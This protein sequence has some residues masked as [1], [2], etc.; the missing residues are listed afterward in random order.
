MIRRPPRSTLSSSSAASD[1]YKRQIQAGFA[2][3]VAGRVEVFTSKIGSPLDSWDKGSWSEK[4]FSIHNIT[5]EELALAP[6]AREVDLLAY[7]WLIDRG[8]TAGERA[9]VSIGFNVAAFDH[10]F[11]RKYL[12]KTMSLISRRAVELNSVCFTLAGWDP[13]P[14]NSCLLYTSPSPRDS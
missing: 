12:P 11:F 6:T 10:P 7:Q 9:L 3:M 2:M 14:G 5:K 4:A 1:V 13:T 8:A